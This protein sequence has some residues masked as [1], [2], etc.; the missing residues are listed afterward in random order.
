MVAPDLPGHGNDKTPIPD[1]TLQAYADHV[2]RVLDAQP[3][4]VILVG[5]SMGGI[6]ITQVAEQRPEKIETLVYLAAFLPRNGESLVMLAKQDSES[7]IMPNLIFADD[8]SFIKIRDE[9]LR[10]AFYGDC[11]EEDTKRAKSLLVPQATAPFATPVSTSEEKFG[12]VQRIYISC[13]G[14]RAI[15]PSAQAKMYNALSCEKVI[16]MD[17][18]HSP[19]LSAPEKLASHLLSL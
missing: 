13:L 7:L 3:G 11:S 10:E 8:Q 9:W 4:K 5:H 15:T 1:I 19:F 16:Y 17:T 12:K 18:S 14:D 6:V 2:C